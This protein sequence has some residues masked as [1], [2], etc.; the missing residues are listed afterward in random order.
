LVLFCRVINVENRFPLF[1]ITLRDKKTPGPRAIRG[2]SGEP[3]AKGA[4]PRFIRGTIRTRVSDG[5]LEVQDATLLNLFRDSQI[6]PA[7][8]GSYR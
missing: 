2:Q 7:A 1:H 4:T 3:S 8:S 5:T 6:K